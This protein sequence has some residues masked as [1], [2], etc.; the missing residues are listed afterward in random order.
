MK[1]GNFG[2]IVKGSLFF[3]VMLIMGFFLILIIISQNNHE[4][5][6]ETDLSA[7]TQE[8]L[9]EIKLC[10]ERI[11]K[12][13]ELIALNPNSQEAQEA[14]LKLAKTY[15]RLAKIEGEEEHF[16]QACKYYWEL[17]RGTKNEKLVL[18]A[19]SRLANTYFVELAD[20]YVARFLYEKIM[21][22]APETEYSLGAS[23]FKT[24]IQLKEE[25][26][27][28]AEAIKSY[29]KSLEVSRKNHWGQVQAQI[30]YLLGHIQYEQG[31]HNLALNAFQKIIDDFANVVDEETLAEA[32]LFI[33]HILEQQN[34][35]N[36]AL[37]T[38]ERA[39]RF[40]SRSI[41][42]LPTSEIPMRIERL[43]DQLGG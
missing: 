25:E 5:L 3:I 19:M 35:L 8:V 2:I 41:L 13:K 32:Y 38:Y 14:K 28:A 42:C 36:L 43:K 7:S 27:T 39:L 30:Y 26:V 37:Q 31:Q 22:K 17:I 18:T 40:A 29:E 21:E 9:A 10:Q 1:K 11:E 16:K 15:S 24:Y 23:L 33:G 6:E 4:R 12:L 34:K 20:P